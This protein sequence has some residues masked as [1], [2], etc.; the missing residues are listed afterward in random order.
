MASDTRP[1]AGPF[2][3]RRLDALRF[4]REG[5][6]LQGQAPLSGFARLGQD[7]QGPPD[8]AAQVAWQ[9]RGEWRTGPAGTGH[10]PWLHLQASAVLPLTCQRCL[11]PVDTPVDVDRWFR[12]VPDEAAAEAQDDDCEED[13]LALEPRPDLLGVVEDELIMSL[14]LVPMHDTCPSRP[15]LPPEPAPP[16]EDRQRPHPFAALARLKDGR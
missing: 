3:P 13:L 6:S 2:N 16:A 15:A 1:A 14:P 4:A 10:E 9:A 12:F 7:L 5:A 11:G 8:P